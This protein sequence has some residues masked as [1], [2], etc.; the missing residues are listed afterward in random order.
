VPIR[1]IL[2]D[3]RPFL[4]LSLLLPSDSFFDF[5]KFEQNK[6]IVWIPIPMVVDKELEGFLISAFTDKESRGLRDELDCYE[7]V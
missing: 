7:K 3:S 1:S 6:F 4:S 5:C 2:K